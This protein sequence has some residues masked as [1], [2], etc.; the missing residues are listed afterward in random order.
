MF[1]LNIVW[2]QGPGE[3]I[4]IETPSNIPLTDSVVSA[5]QQSINVNGVY[6][7]KGKQF[8]FQLFISEDSFDNQ[9]WVSR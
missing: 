6:L 3:H 5:Q 4:E 2:F 9:V 7:F 8:L 1:L